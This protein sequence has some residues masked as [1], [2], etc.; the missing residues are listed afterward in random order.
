MASRLVFTRAGPAGLALACALVA[1][2]ATAFF[3]FLHYVGNL[4][5]HDLAVQRF[6]VE[7]A[8]D[9]PDE[10]HARDYKSK[11]E[12]CEIAGA[13]VAGAKGE[14]NTF[15]D[16]VILR[17]TTPRL[18]NADWA[19]CSALEGVVNGDVYRQSHLK[20]RYWWGG[21]ALYATALRWLSVYE[22][23]EL[24][25][26]ATRV[27]YLLLAV[28]LLLLSPK[29][30]LLAA[31]LVVFGVFF[32]GIEYWADVA[33]GFPYLWTVLFASGLALLLHRDVVRGAAANKGG[34]G[35]GH[36]KTAPWDGTVPVYC[37]AAGTVSAFL[38]LGDGH[39]FLVATWIG[40]VV[41][42]GCGA[43]NAATS[44]RKSALCLLLYG[45]GMV[46]CYAL[47][48][49]VK[50][51][52]E[53]R[54]VWYSFWLGV[55]RNAE[56]TISGTSKTET[57]DLLEY[58]SYFY[59][60]YWPDWLPAHTVPTSVVVFALAASLGLAAFEAR[61]GRYDLLWGV[62]WIVGLMSANFLTFL[63]LDD[64]AYR[65]AR[66]VFVPFA[67]CLSC[68]VL[69]ARSVEWRASLATTWKLPVL[70]VVVGC[71]SLYLA[72]FELNATTKAIESVSELRPLRRSVFDVYLDGER[73]VYVNE[74]CGD[75]D[76]DAP[77]FLH[78]YPSDVANLPN[79]RQPHG[80]DNLDFDFPAIDRDADRCATVR[81][82]P[83]YEIDV[84]R[85]GQY[86]LGIGR[87]WDESIVLKN[88]GIAEIIDSIEHL[89][90][91]VSSVFDVYMDGDH[92]VYV[93][94][95]CGNEDAAPFFLHI[96]PVDVAS[97]PDGRQPH[98][99][100]NLDF[101][102]PPMGLGDDRCAA[103]RRLP[104]YEIE[105]VRTGQY[106]PEKGR[107]WSA[108]FSVSRA[109]SGGARGETPR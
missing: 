81:I 37:F 104:D 79:D 99:F 7:L 76:D 61:R 11:Y 63:V 1:L 103:M 86:L 52:F 85:T 29:M 26:V 68:L 49:A 102:F 31:P 28:S 72:K 88:S 47:G 71:V 87:T 62:L 35:A 16:A 77:F 43:S 100:D 94:E 75:E 54:R 106:T 38:W 30:L 58:L 69:C 80:F 33:N 107:V 101:D 66:F 8:S 53:A 41:W 21:K 20:L 70:L 105:A 97:L 59:A 83:D 18:S 92:L 67:L 4:L 14:K 10:G 50:A 44:A 109:F 36:G 64:S 23:R 65:T 74:E 95:E 24:T 91:A 73:L 90:P 57:R 98:G 22:I 60:T 9:R 2:F 82:L 15:R 46:I 56:A 13:V 3:F 5:P 17:E 45:A 39:T 108:R 78:L 96:Y 51:V 34:N 84:I 25:K 42:F 32:S 6:K 93:K 89:R 12:F 19:R 55:V 40:M 48:Q 27:A